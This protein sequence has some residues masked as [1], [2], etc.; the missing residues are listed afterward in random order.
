MLKALGAE[1]VRCPSAPFGT[2][3]ESGGGRMRDGNVDSISFF[4][5]GVSPN[6]D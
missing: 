5:C 1:V 2:G 3:G 6:V 4:V